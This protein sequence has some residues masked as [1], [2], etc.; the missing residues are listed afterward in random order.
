MS[1]FKDKDF[2]TPAFCP[3][4]RERCVESCSLFATELAR[5]N[6][7]LVISYC[8]FSNRDGSK[9]VIFTDLPVISNEC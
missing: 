5:I 7:R 2:K 9:T 8:S 1:V 3:F 6:P 4:T